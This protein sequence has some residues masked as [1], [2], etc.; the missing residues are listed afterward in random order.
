METVSRSHLYQSAE[1]SIL[2]LTSALGWRCLQQG[3]NWQTWFIVVP[4]SGSPSKSSGKQKKSGKGLV[5]SETAPQRHIHV[6]V[7][8]YHL[9][10]RT[11][12]ERRTKTTMCSAPNQLPNNK[13]KSSAQNLGSLCIRSH[14]A[15]VRHLTADN[16][17]GNKIFYADL[18]P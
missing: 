9:T 10:R 15:T 13:Q 12:P 18:M 17:V 8:V 4:L 1:V 16:P 7:G 5:T 11:L 3:V 6:A 14:C 2:H